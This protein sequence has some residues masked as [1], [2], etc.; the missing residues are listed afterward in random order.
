M[1]STLLLAPLP[2]SAPAR[3]QV[4]DKQQDDVMFIRKQDGG[5]VRGSRARRM[6]VLGSGSVG[7]LNQS[8]RAA[9]AR[10]VDCVVLLIDYHRRRRLF[11]DWIPLTVK[12]KEEERDVCVCV[13]FHV[14]AVLPVCVMLLD[15]RRMCVEGTICRFDSAASRHDGVDGCGGVGEVGG[16]SILQQ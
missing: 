11:G 9:C 5:R 10:F 14:S 6:E 8:R 16:P 15:V 1:D 4:K 7:Q 13:E 3:G 2:L 12:R